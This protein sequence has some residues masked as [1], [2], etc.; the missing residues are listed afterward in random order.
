MRSSRPSVLTQALVLMLVAA[1]LFADRPTLAPADLQLLR[2]GQEQRVLAA[3]Q[4]LHAQRGRLGLDAA[5]AFR[6]GTAHTDAFGETHAR[7]R[8]TYLGVPVWEGD[9]ITH[10]DAAGKHQEPTLHTFPH[11]FISVDPSLRATEALATA[12]ADLR[13]QGAY[14]SEPTAELVVLPETLTALRAGA[15][16]KTLEAANASEI[17]HQVLRYTLAW[18][19]HT[20]L[21]NGTEET[22]HTDYL[23]NAHTGAVL[24]K[25]DTLHTG[26]PGGGGTATPATGS[27]TSQWYG[28]VVLNTA[29]SG[30]TYQL[31]DLTRA[32]G[33]AANST[34][35]LNNKTS[36]KGTLYTDA[37]NAWGDGAWYSGTTISTTSATGQTAAVDAHRGLQATWDFYQSVFGRNGIDN[38]GRAAYSRVHYSRNYDNAFWSDSC[39]CMTY[40]DGNS[41]GSHGEAD[42]DTC[43]HEVSHGVC[44]AEANLTYSGESGGLNEASSDILGTMVEFWVLGGATGSTIPA[45]GSITVGAK[46]VN[47]NYKLFENSWNHTYPNDAL[48]WMHKPS[49]DGIS[50]DSWSSTLGKLDV[51]YSSGVANHFFF[52]L[53]HGSSIDSLTGP[54]ASPLANN[55]ASVTGIGNDK[56]ARIWYKALTDYMTAGTNYAGARTATL[57]AAAD[58]YG[59]SSVE[60]ATVQT[61]WTAVTVQ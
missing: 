44:A 6:P 52:L 25:W 43:G 31:S 33:G 15:R 29:L 36:G 4:Y 19:V 2:A 23:V 35:N 48:R 8:Q 32:A 7:F 11:I 55:V 45:A 54:E 28:S 51:H 5:H 53:A 14:T 46:T 17:E 58:L 21:E 34:Y 3:S 9:A 13:P 20:E 59:T 40:G 18:H 26:K 41:S 38:T 49:R 1:P 57:S 22:R 61:A 37:N 24:K 30:G 42:L 10:M 39:F 27:G 60:Y 12:H 47:A 56:A 16:A 50:P